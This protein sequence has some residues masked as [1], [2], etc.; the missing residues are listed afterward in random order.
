MA[1]QFT[2]QKVVEYVDTDKILAEA[3]E[4]ELLNSD[5]SDEY[6]NQA[7]DHKI[8]QLLWTKVKLLEQRVKRLEENR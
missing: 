3:S 7:R 6:T 5:F 4:K 2:L 1:K 8:I